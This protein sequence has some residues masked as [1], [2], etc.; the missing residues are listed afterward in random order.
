MKRCLELQDD[1]S[2][3]PKRLKIDLEDFLDYNPQE[4]YNDTF[5]LVH[6]FA[7]A[8]KQPHLDALKYIA[9]HE[10]FDV[11]ETLDEN[12]ESCPP[13]LLAVYFCTNT[14]ND[15]HFEAVK[16]ILNKK[17]I[18][19]NNKGYN[20]ITTLHLAV[21][22]DL[23]NVCALLIERGAKMDITDSSNLVPLH[24]ALC[25]LKP[26]IAKL[27]I[28]NMD[29]VNIRVSGKTSLMLAAVY[30]NA[31]IMQLMLVHPS[32]DIFAT[33]QHGQTALHHAAAAGKVVSVKLLIAAMKK[34]DKSLDL[35]TF[36][37]TTG[38][39]PLQMAVA[40]ARYEVI[41]YLL[42]ENTL[43]M[44][45][46]IRDP[47]SGNTSLCVS[48]G[49]G[50]L[51]VVKVLLQYN[52]DVEASNNIGWKAVHSAASSSDPV[53]IL[54]EFIAHNV[55]INAKS[56]PDLITPLQIVV[57]RRQLEATKVLLDNG[58][59][60]NEENAH[61]Q[62]ALTLALQQQQHD[63]IALLIN[64]GAD[65]RFRTI[66]QTAIH[67]A[68]TN[69]DARSVQL[70]LDKD[71]DLMYDTTPVGANAMHLAIARGSTEILNVLL[72]NG[73]NVEGNKDGDTGLQ[74]TSLHIAST[75]S[76]Y[77]MVRILREKWTDNHPCCCEDDLGYQCVICKIWYCEDCEYSKLECDRCG[78]RYQVCPCCND[79]KKR[80][81]TFE[82]RDMELLCEKCH[83]ENRF[84]C[85]FFNNMEACIGVGDCIIITQKK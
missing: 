30:G 47:N 79:E 49:T 25:K 29:D 84:Q 20:G 44:D 16:I 5:P 1:E 2:V 60:I 66:N 15:E 46:N 70:I 58:A 6:R 85:R 55:N 13:L 50:C 42:S 73:M 52:P 36:G 57:V 78:Y 64:R 18:D 24:H 76:R 3:I 10:D 39:N 35:N 83:R 19:I 28:D 69:G 82:W 17:G 33:D 32:V 77:D 54:N 26:D 80:F 38:F 7:V 23:Y 12:G 45:V 53:P 72:D 51:E 81:Y 65:L 27:L 74:V 71:K 63:I 31:D 8:L 14:E 40:H 11:N 68:V 41:E 9:N 37:S 75:L 56:T 34:L 43:G 48:A 67:I 59:D 61:H 4:L 22:Y 21:H 62:T